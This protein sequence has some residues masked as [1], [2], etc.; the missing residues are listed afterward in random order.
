MI[1]ATETAQGIFKVVIHHE[2]KR[3]RSYRRQQPAREFYYD[4]NRNVRSQHADF[5]AGPGTV[6]MDAKSIEWFHKY[7]EPHA[8]K[9]Y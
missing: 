4:M 9:D 3:P 1:I 5:R 6:E 2:S 8:V 7:Y